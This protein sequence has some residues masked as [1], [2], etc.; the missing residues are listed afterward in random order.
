MFVITIIYFISFSS[1]QNH[2]ILKNLKEEFQNLGGPNLENDSSLK[3]D[4]K[5]KDKGYINNV[6]FIENSSL[7][8]NNSPIWNIIYLDENTIKYK[9]KSGDTFEKIANYFN[10]KV[11]NIKTLNNIKKLKV[12]DWIIIKK[13]NTKE[14]VFVEEKN[15]PQ[16][17]NFFSL[18]ANGWNWGKLHNYNAVDISNKCGTPVFAAA[19]GVVIN[20]KDLGSGN[21]GWNEGYGLFVLLEHQNGIKTRYAHLDKVLVNVGEVVKKG[22]KIGL[23]GNTGNS[24]G[25]DGCHLHFE[26]YGAKNPFSSN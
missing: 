5:K 24:E 17:K 11:E 26:V 22:Q 4:Y 8:N 25:P 3:S 12:N 18:P 7:V 1:F 20:D 16:M 13:E 15:L 6:F 14:N 23:M 19:D 2:Q 10:T 9:V 21:S